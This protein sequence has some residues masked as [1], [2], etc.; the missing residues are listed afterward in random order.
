MSL[1]KPPTP[2]SHTTGPSALHL[3]QRELQER[4]RE[5][6]RELQDSDEELER[7]PLDDEDDAAID[8]EADE[9]QESGSPV[10]SATPSQPKNGLCLESKENSGQHM[11]VTAV[12]DKSIN[13]KVY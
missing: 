3:P 7:S 11:E 4:E 12:V 8:V 10:P 5:R 9:E 2:L 6:E 13:Q 1:L